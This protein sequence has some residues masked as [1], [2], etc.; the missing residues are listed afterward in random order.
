MTPRFYSFMIQL[1]FFTEK[2]AKMPE[3][4][5]RSYEC[6][7]FLEATVCDVVCSHHPLSKRHP[8]PGSR[9]VCLVLPETPETHLSSR[10]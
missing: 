6:H 8:P 5:I 2:A 1:R 4:E 7:H 10:A 9:G 3:G